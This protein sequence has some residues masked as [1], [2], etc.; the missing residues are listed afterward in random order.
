VEPLQL[1]VDVG[2]GSGQN[3]NMYTNYFQQVIGVDVSQEQ[4][5]L[6]TKSCTHHNVIFKHGL[7]EHLPVEDE[8]V[9]LL[10]C[11]ASVHWFNME[12][13]YKEVERVLK[14]G[15]VFACY[16]YFGCDPIYNGKSYLSTYDELGREL[17][18]YF[19]ENHKYLFTEYTSLPAFSSEVQVI[20]SRENKF[21]IETDVTLE[22]ILKEFSSWSSFIKLRKIEGEEAASRFLSKVKQK[23]L[24]AM[25]IQDEGVKITRRFNYFLIMWRKPL[26]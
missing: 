14:P 9:E 7:A 18:K 23:M 13:F 24:E 3:T 22:T 21:S 15:G 16:C 26:A 19:T 25:G 1:C 4:V 20:S 10:T 17:Y 11:C 5:Q 12:T 8:S 2:C 6:A